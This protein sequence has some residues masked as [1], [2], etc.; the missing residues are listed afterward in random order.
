MS[1]PS[2]NPPPEGYKN[3]TMTLRVKIYDGNYEV[4]LN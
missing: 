3:E 2:Y 4:T 1:T